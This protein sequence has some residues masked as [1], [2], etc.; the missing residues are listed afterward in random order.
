MKPEDYQNLVEVL[1]DQAEKYG[2]KPFLWVKLSGS[3][4][5]I[6]WAE[7]ASRVARLS[8]ALIAQG[9]RAGDR[10]ALISE[11]RPEWLIAD[12]AIM[13]A[14]AI[15][16]PAYT[17]STTADYQHILENSRA[18]GVII[19]SARLART[20]LPAV[21]LSDTAEFVIAMEDPNISQ[22]LNARVVMWDELLADQLPSVDIVREA[23]S[24]ISRDDIACV[25][26]T[27]GTGGAPKG[28]KLHHGALLHNCAGAC[29]VL[30]DVGLYD[31]V[32]LSFLPL[33]HAYEHSAGQALPVAIGAQIYYAESLDKLAS[34]MAEA[35]PTIMVVVPRLFEML[36][37]RVLRQVEKEGGARKK[38]FDRSL[39]LGVRRFYDPKS[40]GF[41]ERLEDR[42]LDI[43]VR[44][45]VRKRFGGR[46]KALV[47]GGAPLNKEVG[48]FFV[49]LGLPLLQGYGQTESAPII[50]VNR[51]F[52]AKVHTVGP[53]M[54]DVT[55]EIADDGEILVRGDLV[56][57]GYWE[58]DRASAAALRDGWL[59]TGDIGFID[60]D[61]HLVITDRK[62]DII[63]SDKGENISPQRVEG[64]LSLEGEIAQVMIYGEGKPYLVGLVVP[65]PDW[66][67]LWAKENNKSSDLSVVHGD[68]DLHK[69]LDAV[70][71]RVN[72]RL[73]SAER[74][75][76]FT[77]AD[78]PFSIDNEQMTPTLKIRRHIISKAYHERLEALYGAGRDTP[79]SRQPSQKGL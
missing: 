30:E 39:S 41:F 46:L 60:E 59:H 67:S 73:S 10:V 52:H 54:K 58:D 79:I 72:A 17:T 68:K 4:Q 9:V 1:F 8:R 44:S 21:H 49:G 47:S 71:S 7:T 78:T 27:S 53:P 28:V 12:F 40:L 34:N 45:K 50:S 75:R 26:Y 2:E 61:G 6:S 55:V 16:V 66:L 23:A 69:A 74:V 11:N 64:M 20:V 76:R 63:V 70:V 56:M 35:K 51:P 77:I 65:D 19:S 42:V 15:T 25:I 13:A 5:P 57:K 24:S 43:L 38:L 62:K 31:N 37:N 36:R 18:R 14:G 3:Y 22:S 48:E 32:F 29:E 33:S